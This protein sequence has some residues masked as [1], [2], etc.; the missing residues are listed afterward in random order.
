MPQNFRL[1]NIMKNEKIYKL[2]TISSELATLVVIG[3]DY[4]GNSAIEKSIVMFLFMKSNVRFLLFGTKQ[5]IIIR[6]DG[7]V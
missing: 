1:S 2:H 3:T 4:I 5:R 6:S 7:L